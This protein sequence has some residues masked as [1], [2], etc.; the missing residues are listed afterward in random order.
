MSKKFRVRLTN[1]QKSYLE[2][3][4][5]RGKIP[6]RKFKRCMILLLSNSRCNGCSK[7]DKEICELLG[8]SQN[9][10]SRIRKRFVLEGLEAA[11]EEKPRPGKPPKNNGKQEAKIVALACSEPPEGRV[12]W[13]L[14]LLADKIVE[15]D[16]CVPISYKT[17]GEILKKRNETASKKTVVHW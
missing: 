14:H 9:V 3:L 2:K 1:V 15:L 13:T 11:I 8:L 6:A 7:K 17:V 5:S 16:L 10:P 12:R 4:T